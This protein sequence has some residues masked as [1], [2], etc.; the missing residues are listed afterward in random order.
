MVNAPGIRPGHN[1]P[2]TPTHPPLPPW[3]AI[4]VL[5]KIKENNKKIQKIKN[6]EI[7]IYYVF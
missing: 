6:F 5:Q 4:L 3:I 7:S 1:T 2:H